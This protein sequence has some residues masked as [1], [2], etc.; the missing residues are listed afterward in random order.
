MR[1]E[2]PGVTINLDKTGETELQ[3]EKMTDVSQ[4]HK[5]ETLPAVKSGFTQAIS[6]APVAL[7]RVIDV[8][9]PYTGSKMH[10]KLE[11]LLRLFPLA[12]Y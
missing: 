12:P 6:L 9:S 4:P 10:I 11:L 2:Q 1:A 7:C 8:Q 5:H 3:L